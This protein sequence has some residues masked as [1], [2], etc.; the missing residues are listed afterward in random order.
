MK[1]MQKLDWTAPETANQGSHSITFPKI[2]H[3]TQLFLKDIL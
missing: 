3:D 2:V 1:C